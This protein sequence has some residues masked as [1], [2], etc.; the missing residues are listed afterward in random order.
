MLI[1]VALW[2]VINR[3]PEDLAPGSVVLLSGKDDL[4]DAAEVKD[5][6][7]VA[8]HVKVSSTAAA[9]ARHSKWT[10]RSVLALPQH[11]QQAYCTQYHTTCRQHHVLP[12][13]RALCT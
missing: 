10:L 4:M 1:I 11:H 2:L 12:L 3:W 7:D 9:A 8:G 6:L 13:P 5:M